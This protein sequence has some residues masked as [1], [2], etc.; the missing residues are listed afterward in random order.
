MAL[1]ADVNCWKLAKH[2]RKSTFDRSLQWVSVF[3]HWKCI[4]APHHGVWVG[5]YFLPDTPCAPEFSRLETAYKSHFL[6]IILS[7][8]RKMNF[9]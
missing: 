3:R 2:L 1:N 7:F 9:L 4:G 6:Q 8:E 5:C